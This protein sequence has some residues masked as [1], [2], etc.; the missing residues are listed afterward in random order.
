MNDKLLEELLIS[1]ESDTLD[2]KQD[3]YIFANGSEMEKSKLLKDLIAFANTRR[4]KDAYILVG[5]IDKKGEKSLIKGVTE[6]PISNNLQQF[7]RSR[8]NKV[9]QFAYAKCLIGGL[10]IGVY[11][12]P[13]Q[14][15]P[16]W[17]MKTY[18]EVRAGRV[19]IRRGDATMEATPDEVAE[20]GSQN[21][22][23]NKTHTAELDGKINFDFS[24]RPG[25]SL[26][27]LTA[28]IIVQNLTPDLNVVN[29]KIKLKFGGANID[30]LKANYTLHFGDPYA[31]YKNYKFPPPKSGEVQKREFELL[32]GGD[33]TPLR[34]SKY[35]VKIACASELQI[36]KG[37]AAF[38]QNRVFHDVVI[39]YENIFIHEIEK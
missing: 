20:M 25:N 7:V 3:Q 22:L 4:N 17:L 33:H 21:A 8:T 14:S 32:F 12:I 5:I 18:G 35:I 27:S 15:G 2:F 10:E 24:Y 11:T 6:H 38:Y 31:E 28:N 37:N 9:L 13:P 23:S 16:F 19:Y 34:Q 1:D 36:N 29:S 30:L 39:L 26:C